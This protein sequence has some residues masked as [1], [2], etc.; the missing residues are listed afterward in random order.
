MATLLQLATLRNDAV[1]LQRIEAAIAKKAVYLRDYP[2]ATQAEKDWVSRVLGNGETVAVAQRCAWEVVADA[3]L[4]NAV[5][6]A[7]LPGVT[8]E[9]FQAAVEAACMRY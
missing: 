8:D 5:Y 7:G 6:E 1:I 9:N 4:A 2:T 3:R